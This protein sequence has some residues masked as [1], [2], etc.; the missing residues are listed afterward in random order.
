MRP[1]PITTVR[2]GINRLKVKGGA[3]AQSLYDLTNAYITAAGTIVPREGTIRSATLTSATAGLAAFDGVFNVFALTLQSVPAN[4]ICNLLVPPAG[5]IA[6]SITKIWFAKPFLG[7]LYVVAQFNTGEIYHYW[8]QSDG[9]W[10]AATVY[11]TSSIVTPDAPNGLAYQAQRQMAPNPTWTPQT[12]VTEGTMVEPTEYNGYAF[13][14]IAVDGSTPHTGSSE[15]AWPSTSGATLQEYGDFDTNSNDAGTTGATSTTQLGSTITDRYGDSSDV[16]GQSGTPIAATTPSVTAAATVT[17]WAAGTLYAPGS[18]VQPSTGQ[19]AFIDAIPNGDFEAGDDGNW[20]LG[21]GWTIGTSVPY[22][23]S[24]AAEYAHTGAQN[25]ECVMT[26]YGAVTAGQSVTA[27]CYAQGD[28]DGA[29]YIKLKWYDGS[30]T[31][32]SDTQSTQHAGGGGPGTGSYTLIA[33]TG[34]APA[35][36]VHCRVSIMYTTGSSSARAGRADLVVWNLETPAAVSNFLYEAIQSA[37]ASSGSTEP[38]WPTT[39][40]DTV[41]DGGVTWQAVGTSII[42]WEAIP[43]MLSGASEP[44]F[45]ITVGSSVNDPSAFTAQD[46]TVINTSMSWVAINRQIT[47]TNEPNTIAVTIGA[48]HVFAGDKDITSYSAAVDPTDWTSSNNA[49]YLPTGLN[50]YGDNPVAVLALYRGNLMVFNAGGYQM[51]QI[52]PDPANMAL[53]D[54]EPI[55]SIY[56]R[57]AQSVAND[58]LILT[59]VGVRNI[60]FVG[61]T[62]NMQVGNSGQPVDPLIKQQLVNGTYDPLSLYYPGRGQYWLIF[63]A[64]AFVFTVN[65]SGNKSWSRYIFPDVITDWCLNEGILYMRS[66]GNLVWQFD[67]ET[68]LDDAGGA[69]TQ[70]SSTLQW[71]YIDCGAMGFNKMLVGLDLVGYGAASIQIG[72]QQADVTTFSDNAGF[73]TSQNVTA[74][75]TVAIVDT[76]PG[77][78]LPIPINAPSYSLILKFLSNQTGLEAPNSPSWEWEGANLYLQDQGG[79]GVTG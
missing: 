16:A 53:L 2:G 43:I 77:E 71:P 20:T 15:P 65:G 61:A 73:S 72:Y 54:A 10:T 6:T 57:S 51:W 78:P 5:S 7:F 68:L 26:D 60:G 66:A 79:G 42:T 13:R 24:Q 18:V 22:Q 39:E 63:G 17:V 67:Y 75:Y 34:T 8:L 1:V 25:S 48:S 31:H 59:E 38:S 12:I 23:G 19:G 40:G 55:G 45:P 76:V 37:P 58:L 50:S 70:F 56:T 33:V 49:G 27:S 74:A 3:S 11:T 46:S 36:A 30:D 41:I 9:T 62:A 35:G 44:T 4:Y 52:D 32:I 47:D 29:I 14:A 64:Q 28:T 21:T 69:N